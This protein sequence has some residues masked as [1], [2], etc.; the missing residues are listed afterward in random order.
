MSWET[1]GNNKYFYRKRRENGRVVSEYVGSGDV[2]E[3]IAAVA[4]VTRA[5][6]EE[7]H[8]QWQISR[9]ADISIDRQ[10]LQTAR[11][12]RLMQRATLIASGCHTH[13]RQWRRS[14]RESA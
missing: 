3:F 5:M 4:E 6:R 11:I 9:D 13:R 1:R 2:A 12:V 10:L 8:R 7:Q 14:R